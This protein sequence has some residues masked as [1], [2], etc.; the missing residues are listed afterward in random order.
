[1]EPRVRVPPNSDQLDGRALS[2]SVRTYA[3]NTAADRLRRL[4]R[5]SRIQATASPIHSTRK[6]ASWIAQMFGQWRDSWIAYWFA[7]WSE[8]RW[9]WRRDQYLRTPC[10][11][12]FGLHA[13]S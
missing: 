9:A 5:G 6:F 2:E 10:H 11:I 13:V 7:R 4:Q 12:P 3:S 8:R 1:M